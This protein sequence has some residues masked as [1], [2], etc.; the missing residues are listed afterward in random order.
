MRLKSSDTDL[1][2]Q[3]M[4]ETAYA[5]RFV[6]DR[7][8]AWQASLLLGVVRG[9][10]TAVRTARRHLWKLRG[11]LKRPRRSPRWM[12]RMAAMRELARA[13]DRNGEPLA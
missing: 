11:L 12:R 3:W 6:R 10:V 2:E 5:G 13:D 9:D 4:V 7:A 1:L 8:A